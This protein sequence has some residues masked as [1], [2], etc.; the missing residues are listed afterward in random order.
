MFM[1]TGAAHFNKMR[2]DLVQMIPSFFPHPMFI[3]YATGVCEFLG[4]VGLLMPRFRSFTG[5]CLILL[6]LAMFTANVSAA[7]KRVTLRGR[8][9]T[10]LWLRTP[11][12][13]LFI[14][15]IWWA[16]Q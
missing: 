2:H 14:G 9:V 8:P 5:I 10:P 12:Q 4:V 7:C 16:T 11:M 13:I 15:L 6:L 3:V 1:F